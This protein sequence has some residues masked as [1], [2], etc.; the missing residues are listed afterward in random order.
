MTT[1]PTRLSVGIHS[2]IPMP[3]YLGDPCPSPSLS[4]SV[5]LLIDTASA[6]HAWAQH[7]RL[8]GAPGE[9]SKKADLGTAAHDILF[10]GDDCVVFVDAKDWRTKFAQD[11]RDTARAAGKVAL[12]E[13]Q[14]PEIDAMVRAAREFCAEAGVLHIIEAGVAEETLVWRE[15]AAGV[16]EKQLTFN[17]VPIIW[18]D[19]YFFRIRPDL[20]SYDATAGRA[21]ML[22]YKTTEASANPAKFIPGIMRSM[23]YAFTLQFYARGAAALAATTNP[24][25]ANCQQLILVQEQ[26]APYA[27]SL[28]ALDPA[29][30]AI[31]DARV[32]RAVATWKRCIATGRWPAYS[33]GIHY[34]EP[35]AWELAAAEEAAVGDRGNGGAE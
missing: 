3:V 17:G 5:A 21:T 25:L 13:H 18:D 28:I 8:G 32:N 15:D 23:G 11:A 12:L 24:E 30:V 29:A 22:H 27:C 35:T 26:F 14:R 7:P 31:A 2:N 4:S 9:Y 1:E 20:M 19:T 6:R 34:A 10:G 33:P 16:P